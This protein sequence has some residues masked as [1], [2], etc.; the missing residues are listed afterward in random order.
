MSRN[1]LAAALILASSSALAQTWTEHVS[2]GGFRIEFPAPPE[3]SSSTVGNNVRI[4]DAKLEG[5]NRAYSASA[6]YLISLPEKL[7][8]DLESRA[9]GS[10]KSISKM[11]IEEHKYK[12]IEE[13]QSTVS[14]SPAYYMIYETNDG[15]IGTYLYTE[16][17]GNLYRVLSLGKPGIED[18][19]VV[20]RF[21]SSFVLIEKKR[22]APD[23]V[24][25]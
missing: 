12:L 16:K 8:I 22:E 18:T 1:L 19:E 6:V 21:F 9:E 23:P 20:Q 14:G 10:V 4:F 3:L 25:Q 7:R 11:F 24:K 5:E 2:E 17:N 15:Y 13:R